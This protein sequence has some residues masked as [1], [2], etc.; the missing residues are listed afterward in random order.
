MK[1][2]RSPSPAHGAVK[3]AWLTRVY[4]SDVLALANADAWCVIAAHLAA[5]DLAHLSQT[6]VFFYDRVGGIPRLFDSAVRTGDAAFLSKGMTTVVDIADLFHPLRWALLTDQEVPATAHGFNFSHQLTDDTIMAGGFPRAV[7]IKA[8][9]AH[10]VVPPTNADYGDIDI[11]TSFRDTHMALSAIGLSLVG[12]QSLTS[13]PATVLAVAV[14]DGTRDW[15]GT[16]PG[17][18][19]QIILG[20]RGLTPAGLIRAFD[21]S[22]TQVAF[23]GNR[24]VVVTPAFV[25]GLFTNKCLFTNTHQYANVWP[26]TSFSIKSNTNIVSALKLRLYKRFLKY[27]SRGYVDPTLSTAS[28]VTMAGLYSQI[29]ETGEI[30]SA[31]IEEYKSFLTRHLC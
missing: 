25:Y 12:E 31:T 7:L 21:F 14:S 11:W 17:K 24:E 29:V 18:P 28:E 9:R 20:N 10:G 1:R 22:V 15:Y 16:D 3:K 6:N 8:L 27:K 19:I 2:A 23:H 13:F 26:L 5:M 4:H 30:A